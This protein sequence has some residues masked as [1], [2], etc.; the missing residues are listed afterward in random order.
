[1]NDRITKRQNEVLEF[2]RDYIMEAGFSPTVREIAEHFGFTSHTSAEK[3]L[4][5]LEKKGLIRRQPGLSRTIELMSSDNDYETDISSSTI[6]IV[7]QITAGTPILAQENFQG[8]ISL[9]RYF[10]DLSGLF[11]LQVRGDSMIGVGIDDGD[12]AVVRL[13]EEIS[14]GEISVVYLGE[15]YEATIKRVFFERF[16]VRL[17]PENVQYEPIFISK[18]EKYFKI[19]GKVIGVLKKF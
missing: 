13:Q 1:M 15:D 7:G 12:F 6:P 10:G 18:N 14:N 11:A 9:E 5:S 4:V 2:I 16:G 8:F 17:Q 19:G 3:H